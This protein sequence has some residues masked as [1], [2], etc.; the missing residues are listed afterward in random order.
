MEFSIRVSRKQT[1]NG[2]LL[3]S[4]NQTDAL[5]H[6]KKSAFSDDQIKKAHTEAKAHV[7]AI[8]KESQEEKQTSAE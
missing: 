8:K 4:M 2:Q 1:I 5:K 7:E 6:F 3:A